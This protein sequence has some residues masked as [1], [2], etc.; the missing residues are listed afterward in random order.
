MKDRKRLVSVNTSTYIQGNMKKILNLL[1]T[2]SFL[3]N[4]LLAL[5]LSKINPS[6][7]VGGPIK[8]PPPD[9]K[10]SSDRTRH[11]PY[12]YKDQR[13]V[14]LVQMYRGSSH[15]KAL[16]AQ[17]AAYKPKA[18]KNVLGFGGYTKKWLTKNDFNRLLKDITVPRDLRKEFQSQ[19]ERGDIRLRFKDG[20]DWLVKIDLFE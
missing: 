7:I 5:D 18:L 9:I 15:E 16:D 10:S 19:V 4:S 13:G 3:A 17:I 8:R 12:K 11:V 2:G 1:L 6:K 14:P 20:E